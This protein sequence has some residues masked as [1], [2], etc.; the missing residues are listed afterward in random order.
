VTGEPLVVRW[1]AWSGQG[2]ELLALSEG[3]E[4]VTAEAVVMGGQHGTRFVARYRIACDPHW[5]VRTVALTLIGDERAVDLSSDGSG[6]WTDG[7]RRTL[8][9]IE[10]AIDVDISVTPFTNTLPI[11]R[12]RLDAGQS[13]DIVV[14]YLAVP[15]LTIT[16]ERQRYTCL[17]PPTHYRFE[18]LDG[19]FT[20][21]IEVDDRGLV[22]TYPGLFRRVQ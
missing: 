17:A 6:H 22:L 21:D 3:P 12:L 7:A 9:E 13:A 4:A 18:A 10:G 19:G 1:Q 5:R 11:R 14:V 16:S 15:E 20:R 8:P 2:L